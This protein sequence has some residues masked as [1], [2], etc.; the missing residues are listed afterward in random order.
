MQANMD[1][2]RKGNVSIDIF[3]HDLTFS[4]G[5]RWSFESHLGLTLS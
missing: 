2:M 5:E 3:T 1:V 4:G